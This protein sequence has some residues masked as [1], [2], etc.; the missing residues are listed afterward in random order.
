MLTNSAYFS[1]D[2]NYFKRHG[3]YD[4]G[5]P[6]TDEYNQFWRERAKRSI[7]GYRV[8]DVYISGYHYFWLNFCPIDITEETYGETH[9]TKSTNA[10]RVGER[11][12]DFPAMWDVNYDFFIY[13]E[14]AENGLR[15]LEKLDY[16]GTDHAEELPFFSEDDIASGGFDAMYLKP[17]GVGASYMGGSMP[18]RNYFTIPGS[19]SFIVA[20]NKEYLQR[21][22]LYN[23]FTSYL[24][25]INEN[26]GFT[27][28]SDVKKSASE[29]HFRASFK[30]PVTEMES[31][32]SFMSEVIGISL[33]DDVEKIRGKRGKLISYEEIGNFA[34]YIR[35]WRI[36]DD[37]VRQGDI[38]WGLRLGWGTGGTEGSNFSSM[39]QMAYNPR[40]HNILPLNNIWD[41]GRHGRPFCLFT[42]AYMNINCKDENGNSDKATMKARL[43]KK[44]AIMRDSD[45][46]ND[47][48]QHA[49]EHPF[50]P[51]EAML[52]TGVNIFRPD[53]ISQLAI[54]MKQTG[55]IDNMSICGKLERV[56]Q[57]LTFVRTMD[58][59]PFYDYPVKPKS[60]RPGCVIVYD[61]PWRHP[62]TGEIPEW[63]HYICVD[64]FNF[65]EAPTSVSVGAIYVIRNINNFAKP[66]DT[67][68][69]SYIG[70][71]SSTSQ[72]NEILFDLAE[73]YNAK[74]CFE[75]EGSD[76]VGF[77]KA[78]N[79]VRWLF[80]ELTLDFNEN[81]ASTSM[82]SGFGV[83]ISSGRDN[84]RKK[85]GDEYL[86][87]WLFNERST[88][89][90]TGRK[91]YTIDRIPDPGLHKELEVYDDE[92]NFDRIAALRVGMF[93]R[94]EMAWKKKI[95]K[96]SSV[97]NDSKSKYFSRILG[98]NSDSG[99]PN[100]VLRSDRI[101]RRN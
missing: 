71:P 87:D 39:K 77:A 25:F 54:D 16:I 34:N 97:T 60:K 82:R 61:P 50:E 23:K 46:P 10:R 78:N 67:I 72:F 14:V 18:A 93:F 101:E 19:K 12:K 99:L 44:R 28:A 91:I 88:D 47:F 40:P 33:K 20:D 27:K 1:E 92:G 32:D 26:T 95:A 52:N 89:G 41:K 98:K 48:L 37:S 36:T 29:M 2:A 49:A 51:K 57:D 38:S 17:R 30:D 6:G 35:A 21:D 11:K 56:G 83:K 79:K 76:I 69:A 62:E 85:I 53:Y 81:I 15:N 66:D 64:P 73:Y 100:G 45:D 94:K 68:I 31:A 84:T 86:R 90:D 4:C 63:L 13:C 70:R 5:E 80:P 42:P 65:D 59:A 22:G 75:D 7:Y 74:I 9:G 3:K 43:E 58:I 8:G 96:I 55:Y 24:S